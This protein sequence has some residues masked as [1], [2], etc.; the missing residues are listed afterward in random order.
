MKKILIYLS[1]IL[2]SF[3]WFLGCSKSV[4]KAM[5]KAG[6]LKDDFRYGDLYRLSNL[7]EFKEKQVKCKASTLENIENLS[8]CIAG[9]SFT[10]KERIDS[11]DFGLKNYVRLFGPSP[12][13]GYKL[14]PGKNI[15]IIETVERHFRERFEK[16]YSAVFLDRNIP[17]EKKEPIL[18]QAIHYNLPY[19]EAAHQNN[20]F[21]FDF[22]L[23]IKEWKAAMNLSLF[24]K[25]DPRVY[26]SKDGK[27][28]FYY[29]DK[30]KGNTS[31]F[32]AIADSSI[33]KYVVNLNATYAY[34]RKMGFDE[35]YIS[36]IP[37]KSSIIE[38]GTTYNY[39]VSKIETHGGLKM[40]ILS[41]YNAYSKAGAGAYA[42]GDSHWSCQGRQIWLN[43]VNE[44]IRKK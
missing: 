44:K 10:E 12:E 5:F 33:N 2:A 35:V 41:V 42:L 28:I 38:P 9:D 17:N 22:M 39:L 11:S 20:L 24:T 7:N 16:P 13:T 8:L 29:L 36:I 27:H 25:V 3:L 4:P 14:K 19:S 23:K 15:L 30:E 34:Y 1:L 37:N 43:A 21:G 6:L 32:E 26:L 31:G 40:P 18:E